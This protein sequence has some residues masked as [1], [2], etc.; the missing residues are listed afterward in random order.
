MPVPANRTP[1]RLA[2]GNLADL[3]ANLSALEDGEACWAIDANSLYV[4]EVAGTTKTLVPASGGLSAG[5]GVSV[6]AGTNQ[7]TGMDEGSF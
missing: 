6:D 3:Q 1:I 7:I 4:V 2:R 5:N